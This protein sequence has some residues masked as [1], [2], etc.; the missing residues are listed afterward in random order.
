MPSAPNILGELAAAYPDREISD[1]QL[2][3]GQ[4]IRLHTNRGLEIA[5]SFGVPSGDDVQKIAESLYELQSQEL[6]A[7]PGSNG[8]AAAKMWEKLRE[9][10]VMDLSCEQGVLGAP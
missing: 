8:S 6:W 7:E 10:R 2:R 9:K 5:E 1:V 3:S 4:Y